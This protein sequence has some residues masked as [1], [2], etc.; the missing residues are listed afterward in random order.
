MKGVS[1]VIA[2]I[3]MLMITIAL[4][5]MAYTYISGIFS[6]RTSVVL[7]IDNT[8]CNST[9]V[10]VYVRNDGTATSSTVTVTRDNGVGT[11]TIGSIL[12]SS[13]NSCAIQGAAGVGYHS[14]MASA[15]GSTTTEIGRAACRER[16]CTTV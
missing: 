5:G 9:A 2:T 8:L 11:C 16:V 10:T 15:A 4:A 1:T 6:S 3:L 12:A 7:T 13:I 14:V